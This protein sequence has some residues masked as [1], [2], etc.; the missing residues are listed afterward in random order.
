M[1]S[2]IDPPLAVENFGAAGAGG[3]GSESRRSRNPGG[4]ATELAPESHRSCGFG[5]S[6]AE[7][8][9]TSQTSRSPGGLETGIA[10]VSKSRRF[11]MAGRD[12]SPNRNSSTCGFRNRPEIPVLSPSKTAGISGP[13]A[14]KTQNHRDRGALARAATAL[15]ARLHEKGRGLHN[16]QPAATHTFMDARLIPTAHPK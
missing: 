7:L 5:G 8:R 16:A 6:A 11:C 15:A 4:S 9:S 2:E 10:K 13:L 3:A 14:L 12:A 1:R